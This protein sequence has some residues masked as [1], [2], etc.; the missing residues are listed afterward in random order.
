ML[1]WNYTLGNLFLCSVHCFSNTG[2]YKYE[3]V[4]TLISL[5]NH[6]SINL[7]TQVLSLLN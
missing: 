2:Q 6:D 5:Q 7:V 4:P 1:K 3:Y